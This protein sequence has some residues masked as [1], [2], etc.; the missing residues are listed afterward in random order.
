MLQQMEL[1]EFH[2]LTVTPKVCLKDKL[3]PTQHKKRH[4]WEITSLAGSKGRRSRVYLLCS[5]RAGN[6]CGS[7]CHSALLLSAHVKCIMYCKWYLPCNIKGSS[8]MLS[9]METLPVTLY[10]RNEDRFPSHVQQEVGHLL[11]TLPFSAANFKIQGH[12]ETR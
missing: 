10:R 2:H 4:L 8:E 7:L 9:L 1:H 3:D 6:S 5:T 11:P 12:H